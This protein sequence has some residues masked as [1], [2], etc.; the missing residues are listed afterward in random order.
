MSFVRCPEPYDSEAHAPKVLSCGHTYCIKDIVNKLIKLDTLYVACPECAMMCAAPVRL[1]ELPTNH[2]LLRTLQ[3]AKR[4]AEEDREPSGKRRTD[5]EQDKQ[6][7]DALDQLIEKVL[8]DD[9]SLYAAIVAASK[10]TNTVA[11]RRIDEARAA[12][13]QCITQFFEELEEDA[14]NTHRLCCSEELDRHRRRRAQTIKVVNESFMYRADRGLD[15]QA[16]ATQYQ[17][18]FDQDSPTLVSLPN[19]LGALN[20]AVRGA[21]KCYEEHVMSALN[22][23]VDRRVLR[24][25]QLVDPKRVLGEFGGAT[26]H[27][28][29]KAFDERA[30]TA[31][32]K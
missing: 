20:P 5:I 4:A 23:L 31:N 1:S 24:A 27:P 14:D 9:R 26:D 15:I 8:A 6:A 18:R 28:L 10:A 13:T 11:H 25:I 16:E 2:E 29:V 30:A 21:I 32:K 22:Q 19:E 17:Q 12:A 3:Q 7:S